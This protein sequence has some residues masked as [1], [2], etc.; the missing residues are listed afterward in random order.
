MLPLRVQAANFRVNTRE[1]IMAIDSVH[2]TIYGAQVSPGAYAKCELMRDRVK[3]AM[4]A[5][6][7]F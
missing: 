5:R 2:R 4:R 6:R 7:C 3:V 1:S